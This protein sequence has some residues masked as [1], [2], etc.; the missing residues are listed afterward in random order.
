MQACSSNIPQGSLVTIAPENI[1]CDQYIGNGVQWSAYPHADS[2]D[3]QWGALM[4]NPA[5][6]DTLYQ[7]LDY[8]QPQFIRVMDQANWRYYEG[9]DAAGMPIVNFDRPE[10]MALYRLLDYCQ[11]RNITVV[12]G[13]WG[14]PHHM[15]EV[16]KKEAR[17]DGADDPRWTKMIIQYLNHL[18]HEKGYTCLK[19][20]NLIN[21]P[22][23]DWASTLGNFREWQQGVKALDQSLRQAGLKHQIKIAGPGSVPHYTYPEYKEEYSG[24]DWVKMSTEQLDQQLGAYEIHAYLPAE[25]VRKGKAVEFTHFDQDFPLTQAKG[26]PFFVGE[27]GLKEEWGTPAYHENIERAKQDPHTAPE[28]SQMSVYDYQYGVDMT[29]AVIQYMNAGGAG[30]I[31]WD[32]DDAMHTYGDL[33]NKNQLKRWGFWNIL[34]TEICDNPADE[35]IRPWYYPW[36]WSCKYFPANTTILKPEFENIEGLRITAGKF[37]EDYSVLLANNCEQSHALHLEI[38]SMHKKTDFRIHQYVRAHPTTEKAEI[39]AKT[40]AKVKPADGIAIEI[41]AKSVMVLTTFK[42]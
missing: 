28:D 33:G 32:V 17:L 16:E 3:A 27:I 19:Y 41:P 42:D 6:W 4:D 35:A 20:Y 11:S 23:G 7:R 29:D 2:E 13:E 31:A 15:H 30:M 34:G 21:E 18:I 9:L 39:T 10:M 22:N 26:K 24:K 14:T 8:M 5:K 1:S 37:K 40:L 25:E 38:P 36:S 12:I